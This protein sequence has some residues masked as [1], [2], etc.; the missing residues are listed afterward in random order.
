MGL[1]CCTIF[2]EAALPSPALSPD[3]VSPPPKRVDERPCTVLPPPPHSRP[4][5]GHTLYQ[6]GLSLTHSVS[7]SILHRA[8]FFLFFLP[9]STTLCLSTRC[10]SHRLS[11]SLCLYLFFSRLSALPV[12][13]RPSVFS[14]SF[15]FLSHLWLFGTQSP[16]GPFEFSAMIRTDVWQT[17][18]V[19]LVGC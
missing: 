13:F 15:P 1:P 10:T 14:F 12:S 7:F 17:R 3:P 9:C 19:K 2:L 5:L 16:A 11:L 18:L 8:V 6:S 4:P